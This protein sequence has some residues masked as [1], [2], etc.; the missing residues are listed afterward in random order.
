MTRKQAVSLLLT[1]VIVFSIVSGIAI[2]HVAGIQSAQNEGLS[3]KQSFEPNESPAE[4]AQVELNSSIDAEI[5]E[6]DVDWFAVNVPAGHRVEANI[7]KPSGRSELVLAL[8][9]LE[10]EVDS[11]NIP[12]EETTAFVADTTTSSTTY[13]VRVQGET[14][15]ANSPYTLEL[16][17]NRT[18]R[19]EPNEQPSAAVDLGQQVRGEI[20]EHD[21]DYFQ[22]DA[23]P[24]ERVVVNLTKPAGQSELE[25][26]LFNINKDIETRGVDIDETH[27][28]VADTADTPTT[29]YVLV[30]G[31]TGRDSSPYV[32]DLNRRET[33]PF[34]PNED[35]IGAVRA[36]RNGNVTGE[37]TEYDVDWFRFDASVG[38]RVVVNLT[39]P[40]GSS[41]LDISLYTPNG[42]V[43]A[44]EINVDETHGFVADTAESST[45]YFVR[46][47]GAERDV[48][49][50]TLQVRTNPTEAS[51]T[52]TNQSRLP[53]GA[54]AEDLDRGERIVG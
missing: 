24:G 51:D 48:S 53:A 25:I 12:D 30:R 44:T 4:A 32:L 28:F 7:T 16:S 41:D 27:G 49:T 42:E 13:Y 21:V 11:R 45:S 52:T 22:F 6:N 26:L 5:T 14:D 34:E 1:G 46:V 19:F 36:P 47:A 43:D 23:E 37:V 3:T 39:K 31:V 2:T 40:A 33:D 17:A 50:Y 18:D 20:T 9:T 15:D 8:S 54:L 35:R 29:Y 10:R 38:D